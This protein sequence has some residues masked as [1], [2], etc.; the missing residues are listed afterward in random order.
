MSAYRVVPASKLAAAVDEAELDRGRRG[1]LPPLPP[2]ALAVATRAVVAA[3]PPAATLPSVRGRFAAAC[4]AAAALRVAVLR[5]VGDGI[6]DHARLRVGALGLSL[7][8]RLLSL[9]Y[10]SWSRQGK[11]CG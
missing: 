11:A 9:Y 3:V 5:R 4:T 1:W 2:L 10:N 8:N 6:G 7:I